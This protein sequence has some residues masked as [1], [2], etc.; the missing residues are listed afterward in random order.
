MTTIRLSDLRQLAETENEYLVSI[1]LPMYSGVESKQTPVRVKNHLRNADELLR[2]RGMPGSDAKAYL[3]E[4]WRI[5]DQPSTWQAAAHGLAVFIAEGA[6]RVWHLPFKC[7][8]VGVVGPHF[9]VLPILAWYAENASYYVLAV[10]QNSVRLFHG[11]RY[12]LDQLEVEGLPT[13]LREALHYDQREGIFQA[14]SAS[15]QL[16]GKES[17]VFHGQGG[18]V[19]VSKDELTSFFREIDRS[20]VDVLRLQTDPLVFAGVDY[21][22]PIYRDV[23]SY[24]HLLPTH[25]SGNPE[26]W[27]AVDIRELAW[28]LVEPTV[29]NCR[30]AELAKYGNRIALGQ[31]SNRIDDVIVAAHAGAV[32][33]LF[34]DSTAQKIGA[35]Q[36]EQLN[37]RFDETPQE[38]SEDLVNLAATLVLRNGGRVETLA[39]GKVPGGVAMAAVLR[40]AYPPLI[41]R[42]MGPAVP[43]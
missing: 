29:R 4:A 5:L 41:E 35:F 42:R 8:E 43:T 25:I 33:T 21:L 26:L 39:A 2:P 37:V 18:E 23:N 40:Y 6:T 14:H 12:Q 16:P 38:D 7:D 11:T 27:S 36:P 15:P 30:E 3:A 31:T 34:I 22:F 1:Y 20:L 28:P 32:E 9:H 24:P 13:G 19:D 17:L 10:S